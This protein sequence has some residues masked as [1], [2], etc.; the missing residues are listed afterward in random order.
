MQIKQSRNAQKDIKRHFGEEVWDAFLENNQQKI[1][2]IW[3]RWNESFNEVEKEIHNLKRRK[4]Q[5]R[6][7]ASQASGGAK[8]TPTMVVPD[9]V[10]KQN[11]KVNRSSNSLDK[12]ATP[13]Q[14]KKPPPAPH[15]GLP[16]VAVQNN[17]KIFNNH[18]SRIITVRQS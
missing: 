6:E 3:K 12:T 11:T 13:I 17:Q 10:T 4:T 15:K 8:P 2:G 14:Q 1:Q 18:P 9:S 5:L 7:E 16:A